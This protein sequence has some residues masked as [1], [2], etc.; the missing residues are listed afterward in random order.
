MKKMP[1]PSKNSKQSTVKTRVK[2]VIYKIMFSYF[3]YQ[4]AFAFFIFFY[5][6]KPLSCIYLKMTQPI[7]SS[8][9]FG[10]VKFVFESFLLHILHL[11]RW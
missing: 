1:P 6:Q 2:T 9:D 3:L 10:S 8:A 5:L 7:K 4:S 11:T